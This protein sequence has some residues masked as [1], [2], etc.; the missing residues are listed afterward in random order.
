MR[1]SLSSVSSVDRTFHHCLLF[2]L[3]LSLTNLACLTQ[4][5]MM[6]MMMMRRSRDEQQDWEETLEGNR[7]R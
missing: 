6:R 4:I 3:C 2:H 5:Q 7:Q 1:H